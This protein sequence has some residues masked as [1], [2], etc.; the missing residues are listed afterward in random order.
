[1]YV[2][3]NKQDLPN[4]MNCEEIVAKLEL[5]TL[6]NREWFIQPC[7]ALTGEGLYD[8]LEW[9]YGKIKNTKNIQGY[10]DKY[11]QLKRE[12]VK[13]GILLVSG[14][15][16]EL[17]NEYKLYLT[18]IVSRII[19]DY[20]QDKKLEYYKDYKF[21]GEF[22]DESVDQSYMKIETDLILFEFIKKATDIMEGKNGELSDKEFMN[23]IARNDGLKIRDIT[24]QK[25][26]D[27]QTE[28]W[29][30]F[31]L[32]RMIYIIFKENGRQK[33]LKL[34]WKYTPH[35]VTTTYFWSQLIYF[36]MFG[37]ENKALLNHIQSEF[38]FFLTMNPCLSNNYKSLIYKY[39]THE[40]IKLS[41]IKKDEVI[42]PDKKNK[43]KLQ[44]PS[45]VTNIQK[46][47]EHNEYKLEPQ[48]VSNINDEEF[49]NNFDNRTYKQWNK[50]E[51]FL[52]VI[53]CIVHKY[54]GTQ[55][56]VNEIMQKWKLF[57]GNDNYNETITY[58]WIHMVRLFRQ[59][60][61]LNSANNNNDIC[62]LNFKQYCE[63]KDTTKKIKY[64]IMN[65][66]LFKQFYTDK[67]INNGKLN[68]ILPD[69]KKLPQ[70]AVI[71]KK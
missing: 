2:T 15:M 58:F 66:Q 54:N 29:N 45:I 25:Y 44:L 10:T 11:W 48:K 50:H 43:N 4:A 56:C 41:Y 67:A 64:N 14:Y 40:Q 5:K 55:K 13:K 16:R 39:Y 42:L 49:M 53:W 69:I 20:F 12:S 22:S 70:M 27:T 57:I 18:T 47:K 33:G 28:K 36:G 59:Y 9:I 63:L 6:R 24:D 7:C 31:D 26:C 60:Y 51:S 68:M 34:I 1:M 19:F 23:T 71:N 3:A 62:F 46:L 38:R 21:Y 17:N 65:D 61:L 30:H 37:N 52:R 32:L 8:G 35:N